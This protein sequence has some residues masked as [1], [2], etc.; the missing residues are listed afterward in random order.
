MR[1]QRLIALGAWIAVVVGASVGLLAAAHTSLGTT[2]SLVTPSSINGWSSTYEQHRCL[3][4]EFHRAVPKGASVYVN[5]D[6]TVP[7]QLLLEAAALWAR[8]VL[9]EPT[10]NWV[11]TLQPGTEC[12]GYNLSARHRP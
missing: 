4:S 7:R 1:P 11:V 2:A 6:A 10:A 9:N 3:Q 5:S 12:V 8:P